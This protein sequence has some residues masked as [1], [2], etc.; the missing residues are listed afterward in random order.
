MTKKTV[1]LFLSVLAVAVFATNSALAET[2]SKCSEGEAYVCE[3]PD[4]FDLKDACECS[5]D[6]VPVGCLE[7]G[8]IKCKSDEACLWGQT[9]NAASCVPLNQLE[10]I[11]AK[12]KPNPSTEQ[13]IKELTCKTDDDCKDS[14]EGPYCH[15]KTSTCEAEPPCQS[16]EDCPAGRT[17]EEGEC[18]SWACKFDIFHLNIVDFILC[19]ITYLVQRLLGAIF[20]LFILIAQAFI[21]FA[22]TINSQI[23]SPNSLARAGFDIS[24]QFTNIFFVIGL[25]AIA[26]GTMFR[27]KKFGLDILPRFIITAIL[28]NF[29]FLVAGEIVHVAD[30]IT[31]SI[32]HSN[33]F[34]WE[35][36]TQSA[37]LGYTSPTSLWQGLANSISPGVAIISSIPSLFANAASVFA[38]LIFGIVSIITFFAIAIM[39]IIRYVYLTILFIALP[40]AL[41]LGI[42]PT[43][44][45][46][47]KESK[48]FQKWIKEFTRWTLFAPVMSFF[49]FFSYLML[50][51]NYRP[52][53]GEFEGMAAVFAKIGDMVVLNGLLLGGLFAAN[54]LGITMGKYF[55]DAATKVAAGWPKAAGKWAW[56]G[57]K[58]LTLAAGARPPTVPGGG[59]TPSYAQ[60][61]SRRLAGVP[62][63]GGIGAAL[64]RGA[65]ASIQGNIRQ[66]QRSYAN[67]DD[68]TITRIANSNNPRFSLPQ[69]RAALL[70][71]VAKRG[72][73]ERINPDRLQSLL[74]AAPL[75]RERTATL[76]QLLQRANTGT[77]LR[78]TDPAN[79]NTVYHTPELRRMVLDQIARRGGAVI[80][81]IT[82]APGG[83]AA[84][85]TLMADVAA[86]G[87]EGEPMVT[88]FLARA[89][90][91]AF[92]DF[93]NPGTIATYS[94]PALQKAVLEQISQR[95]LIDAM[96]TGVIP[97]DRAMIGDLVRNV[98]AMGSEGEPAVTQFLARASN[99]AFQ[100]FVSP[101]LI[102]NYS[103]PA[104][105]K[106]V[107][108][109][110]SQRKLIDNMTA[111]PP[112]QAMVGDLVRNAQN[113]G[114][115]ELRDS[116]LWQRPEL[117]RIVDPVAP[118]LAPEAI[119]RRMPAG[120]AENLSVV[121]LPGRT[122]FPV[123]G[124]WDNAE[125][126]V[127]NLSNGQ[128]A[129]IG[130]YGSPELRTR[131]VDIVTNILDEYSSGSRTLDKTQIDVLNRVEDFFAS[132]PTWQ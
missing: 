18:S 63:I 41:F 67:L 35:I 30:T 62:I 33:N 132:N 60:R 52:S 50:S 4:K 27:Q 85:T 111:T 29:S 15:P 96:A 22:V 92:Q 39:L 125:N 104:L 2:S 16:N 11:F 51:S 76:T 88:Q 89:S 71:E 55:F 113:E 118:E 24:L 115:A 105:Q 23:Y 79:L 26:F 66:L 82:G 73:A 103:T 110:I 106:A 46:G 64:N 116:V 74:Q 100:D 99:A 70:K 37:F 128:F 102:D 47:E 108:E 78:L 117:G 13:E 25:I 114:Q 131:I 54:S 86:S 14:H 8:N 6:D 56:G 48:P 130:A 87:L 94:T 124:A 12:K 101:S 32:L 81:Q 61:L 36:L 49:I 107:L 83:Q 5:I 97:G 123:V 90:N 7:A 17:C 20:G 120:K 38:Y 77:F 93:V 122:V 57:A 65:T 109:Q 44:S 91:A 112:G 43:L 58:Q 42:F 69:T 98:A 21:E 68:E 19:V 40:L 1:F 59:P 84:L 127:F 126:I 34:A 119:I 121:S 9:R 95:K 3:S 129:R 10:D 45:L 80:D 53:S 75:D 31:D 72:L 28:I